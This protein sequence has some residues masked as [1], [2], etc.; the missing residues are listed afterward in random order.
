M[1]MAAK[2]TQARPPS[3]SAETPALVVPPTPLMPVKIL[4]PNGMLHP[5]GRRLL[6]VGDRIDLPESEALALVRAGH[7]T[8]FTQVRT[9][10]QDVLVENRVL[11][12]N[13]MAWADP[14]RAA[15]LVEAK[16]VVIVRPAP[17]PGR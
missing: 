1:T 8:G 6:A 16:A 10:V 3:A 5:G 17:E 13:E 14:A 7:A 12:L 4:E 9:L 15:N 11:A 2:K